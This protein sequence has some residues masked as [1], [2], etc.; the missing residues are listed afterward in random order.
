MKKLSPP[1][2]LADMR[3]QFFPILINSQGNEDKPTLQ[4]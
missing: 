3:A 4:N 1:G 2:N